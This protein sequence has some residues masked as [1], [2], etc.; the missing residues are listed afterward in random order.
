MRHHLPILDLIFK[1]A[2]VLI[3]LHLQVGRLHPFQLIQ[4]R[5]THSRI[6][7]GEN[8]SHVSNMA[9]NIQSISITFAR[10]D[11]GAAINGP[12]EEYGTVLVAKSC[13]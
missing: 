2:R 6:G 8:V 5:T 9:W 11:T 1:S 4:N 3:S 10:Y 7:H 12:I 13:W